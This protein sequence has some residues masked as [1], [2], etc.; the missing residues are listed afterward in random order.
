MEIQLNGISPPIPTPFNFK[1]GI[2]AQALKKNLGYWNGFA[3]RGFVVLGSNGEFVFLSEQ[4]KLQILEEAR[5]AIPPDK[6]LIAGTGCQSTLNTI[7]LTE[8][9]AKIGADAAS[10]RCWPARQA[11]FSRLYLLVQ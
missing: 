10:F 5:A 9:A 1:G 4:E 8:A 2:A 7:E 3:L 11:F 6:L